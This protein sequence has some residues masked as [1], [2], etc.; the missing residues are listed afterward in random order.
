MGN[1]GPIMVSASV[2]GSFDEKTDEKSQFSHDVEE[3]L[4]KDLGKR[5]HELLEK[6]GINPNI[7]IDDDINV[8]S[9]DM[10]YRVALLPILV[11]ILEK[12]DELEGHCGEIPGGIPETGGDKETE[13]EDSEGMVRYEE[14]PIT[15]D[16]PTRGGDG[17]EEPVLKGRR[18][19]AT[20]RKE[21]K[22]P[23]TFAEFNQKL[24]K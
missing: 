19:N 22:V 4:E 24:K 5:L 18:K 2:A 10:Y 14:E 23:G 9:G 21:Q 17:T 13:G 7:G 12:I 8:W 15:N 16:P 3:M 6:F 11:K 1:L 20:N